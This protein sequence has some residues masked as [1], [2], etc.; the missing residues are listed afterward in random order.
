MEFNKLNHFYN[1][2]I[3]KRALHFLCEKIDELARIKNDSVVVGFGYTD[4][5]LEK[6]DGLKN[7]TVSLIPNFIEGFNI[8]NNNINV[9]C[10]EERLPLSENSVGLFVLTHA[11]ENAQNPLALMLEINQVVNAGGKVIVVVPNRVGIWARQTKN[12]FGFGRPYTEGQ[13]R[14]LMAQ[15][16]FVEIEN[17]YSLYFPPVDYFCNEKVSNF[18]EDWIGY[19]MRENSGV[20]VGVYEKRVHKPVGLTERKKLFELSFGRRPK[21]A[22]NKDCKS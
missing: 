15:A 8:N 3:G 6:I 14:R 2:K 22:L 12:P 9:V 20:I 19:F 7:Y 18:F 11:L 13:L 1:S 17:N 5:Y 21:V 16:G 4:P 10:D